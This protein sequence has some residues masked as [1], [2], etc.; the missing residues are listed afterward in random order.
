ME[1][2]N[3]SLAFES[4]DFNQ[5]NLDSFWTFINPPVVDQ[6]DGSY[7]LG[8]NGYLEL[9]A[10]GGRDMWRNSKDGVRVMQ[11][12]GNED[13]EAEVQFAS[14]PLENSQMQGILVEQDEGNWLRFDVFET[15]S[16]LSI[17]A[18]S[19]SNGN[20]RVKI[21]EDVEA[22]EARSL[23]VKRQGDLW[24]L[25]H[26]SDG[27][28][29]TTAGSFTHSL[30]V[31]EVGVFAANAG[32]NQPTFTSQVDYFVNTA[33][34]IVPNEE[35]LTNQPPV[36]NDDSVSVEPIP[37]PSDDTAPIAGGEAVTS[38]DFNQTNLDSFW[39]FINPPVVDQ[40][41]GSYTLGGN[42][43]L[44][45][46]A[47]GGRDMWRNSKDGVRVMQPVGNEDFEAEVQFAS[48]P[49][50]NSQMQ[51]ILVEQDEGNWLRFDVFET[52]SGLSI[53]A[54]S[55][56]NGNSRVK[57][58]EDVEAGE[59][60]SLKVKR[61]GDLWSLEHSSD[62]ASWTTAGSFT[63]S[64]DVNEVGVFAAN[65]GNNQPT[66]TSQ[67]DYFVNTATPI[68]PNEEPLT[69]QPPV[70]NDDSV[71][72][73]PIPTPSDDTAPIAG[74][75][76][77]P[78]ATVIDLWY[79]SQQSFGQIGQPQV[80]ANILGNVSDGISSLTYSLNGGTE[81]PVSISGVD[82]N[83]RLVN[84]GD[85]NIDLA[86]SAL[87][88]SPTDDVVE[89]KAA[90]ELSNIFTETVTVDYES[91]NTWPET[92]SI[93][94][95]SVDNINDVA[96]VVDGLWTL[97]ENG[98]RTTEPGY[99]RVIAVGDIAWKDYEVTV[100]VT[101]HSA[102][103]FGLVGLL[104]RWQGHQP[105]NA[106]PHV[107]WRTHGSLGTYQRRDGLDLGGEIITDNDPG[108]VLEEEET[109]I[110]KMRVETVE[111]GS[112][113]SLR[114]WEQNQSEPTLW[115]LQSFRSSTNDQR[116]SNGSFLLVAHQND[117]TFGD[118]TTSPLETDF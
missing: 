92:Y 35:P 103:R 24:S 117:V 57:I 101:I 43:Y 60:R 26:S 7:T 89:I 74:G 96:Q 34:P 114:V 54:G 28:S 36:A 97:T 73:E 18:G 30:D 98:V 15:G 104:L 66:F 48:D 110:F 6:P 44:E 67:V 64:L 62:G 40:P 85:F 102:T 112:I 1:T 95:E 108:K 100:P 94:W 49:L 99:D 25:E 3:H 82:D 88:P 105:D 72:V 78:N 111:E 61:Q 81:I 50:E 109:Y 116:L 113:Y 71:S 20:S 45:L 118:V 46:S 77:D 17:F 23:K 68:V 8:G 11:P 93:N 86:Y 21:W 90:D 53:F 63:H 13:F 38:D 84:K 33:T 12:V 31:N 91:G 80:W 55:T 39:T 32:N 83:L 16:G 9:S 14:D 56:S 70:A 2:Y 59:A 52:G 29:W 115:D 69:N 22:G 19:T 75:E 87:D 58:W 27:A 51:G 10:P 47:P 42:G 4:D 107:Q 65:A 79:G 41:D 5:T 106:Q 76:T 37:T